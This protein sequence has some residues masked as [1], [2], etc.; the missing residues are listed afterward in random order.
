MGLF[1]PARHYVA[2]A[3]RYNPP[4]MFQAEKFEDFG[5]RRRIAV[6]ANAGTCRKSVALLEG[7]YLCEYLRLIW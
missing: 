6:G 4:Q 2:F 7:A 1:S 3:T 5:K